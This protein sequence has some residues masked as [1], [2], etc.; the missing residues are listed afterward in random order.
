MQNFFRPSD[1][2]AIFSTLLQG[3]F[4]AAPDPASSQTHA[5]ERRVQAERDASFRELLRQIVRVTI[6]LQDRL[7]RMF[8]PIAQRCHYIFSL[9]SLSV[10]FRNIC[11]TLPA[12]PPHLDLL[13][14][15]RNECA[16]IY[17]ERMI[18]AVDQDRYRRTF[19]TC[20]KREFAGQHV[21]FSF[22]RQLFPHHI[23]WV[24]T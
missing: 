4:V 21:S 12:N 20:V 9:R 14:L 10:I 3:H 23:C 15:W 6:G 24:I 11:H 5:E 16:W 17:A 2:E 1:Q 22:H 8:L 19:V 13:R 7:T 18:D